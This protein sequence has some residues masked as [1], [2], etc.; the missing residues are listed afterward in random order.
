MK[1]QYYILFIFFVFG[2][3]SI[4]QAN[5]QSESELVNICTKISKQKDEAKYL[6]DY[7]I[8]L[9]S[10][11]PAP[12]QKFSVILRRDTRYKF[13][14]CNSRDYP[15]KAILQV[16]DNQKM[17]ATTHLKSGKD[18]R[19]VYLDVKKTSTYHMIVKFQG[20]KEGLAVVI[21]SFVP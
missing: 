20:G 21:L 3:F 2:L 6:N 19:N 18:L 15:G 1:H 16:F 10:S 9:E 11:T 5:A 7:K 17:I 14:L 13:T 12:K 4:P 8:R